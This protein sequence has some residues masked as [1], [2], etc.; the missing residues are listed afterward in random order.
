MVGRPAFS[1]LT[2]VMRSILLFM[3]AGAV[4]LVLPALPASAQ[5]VLDEVVAAN[6]DGLRD[7]DG[8]SS[9][10]IELRNLT[11][12]PLDLTGWGLSDEPAEPFRWRL[13]RVVLPP[14]GRLVVFASGKDRRLFVNERRTLVGE[15]D[16]WRWLAPHGPPPSGWTDPGFDDSGWAEGPSGFGFGDGDDATK[17]V[18]PTFYLRRSFDLPGSLPA[19]AT[20]LYLHVDC[21][22]GF[23]AWLNGVEIA[24]ENLGAPGTPV[25]WSARADA[26]REA[27]LFRGLEVTGHLVPDFRT[28]LRPGRNVLAVEVHDHLRVPEDLS[29][30][31]FLTLGLAVPFPGGQ[32]A[33]G[34]AFPRH[35]LHTSFRLDAAGESLVLTEPAGL[36]VDRMDFGPLGV[37]WSQGHHLYG[38]SRLFWFREPTPGAANSLD[39]RP[40]F[41]ARV[42][43]SP[44]GGF[45]P[46]PV[47]VTLSCPDPAATIHY[48]LDG[49]EPTGRHPVYTAPLLLDRE[50]NVLRARAFRKGLWPG[51]ICT[52]TYVLAT[53]P[54]L[55][56][57][58]LVTDPAN[59]WDPETGIYVK[60]NDYFPLPPYFGANFWQ[61]WERPVHLEYLLPDG[62]L[63]LQQGAGMKIHGGWSRSL[64]QKSLRLIARGGYGAESLAWPFFANLPFPDY[65]R[66][67][68]RNAGN[69]WC[70]AHMRDA[71]VQRL[72]E[73]GGVDLMAWQP[74][75]VLLNGEYWGIHNL[76]ERQ[77]R[78]YLEQHH[79]VDPDA[80]DILEMRG[81]VVQG[82]AE[83]YQELLAFVRSHDLTD[84]AAYAQVETLMDTWE[85]AAYCVLQIFCANTDWPQNNIKYWRPRTPDGRWRWLLFDTDFG[86]GG[87]NG[88]E[89]PSL[90]R[91]LRG[92]NGL[93]LPA[94]ST[95]LFRALMAS[96]EFQRT[97]L[98]IYADWLN[99]RFLPAASLPVLEEAARA[100][101]P[102]I[103]AHMRRWG[104]DRQRWEDA[105]AVVRDFVRRR[106][107]VARDHILQEFHLAGTWRLRLAVQPPGAG[108]IALEALTVHGP[109]QGQYF[110]GV[111]VR[112]RAEANP[113]WEFK[114]WSDPGLPVQAQ[115]EVDPPGDLDLVVVFRPADDGIVIHEINYNPAPGFDPG[116]WVELHNATE[117]DM[118]LSG[119]VF[120]DDNDLHSFVLPP[121]TVLPPRGYL[122]LC[123]SLAAFQALF[124]AAGPALGDLGFAFSGSG[125]L[126]RLY[127]A[128]GVLVDQV[129]Y[130]DD[131]PWP[132]E[133]DGQGPTLELYQPWLDNTLAASWRASVAAHGTPGARNSVTP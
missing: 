91:M 58:S 39:G 23:V 17:V 8:D 80:V 81:Q 109:W 101:D 36:P 99:S 98:D 94:W 12:S 1:L 100:F 85:Y 104:F 128:A 61:D 117:R 65:R 63:V 82:S 125:E 92:A 129:P 9:D 74:V 25:A 72:V 13:P 64:P 42:T 16:R 115:V 32:G 51:P 47:T 54:T 53:P 120:R 93:L 89:H 68:L 108:R 41:V 18:A 71:L 34:L 38:G 45:H 96:P 14:R 33:D 52:A 19:E 28:L 59:L 26:E 24:R 131:P 95:E 133:P 56:V 30:I 106:P 73:G 97:F 6:V 121:G 49:S 114:R 46:G 62:R 102:E 110:L 78:W 5:V 107:A 4:F 84:P 113:G 69:D 88:V 35:V 130:D 103:E 87:E 48:S 22:D 29:A 112:L 55:P 40:G 76:R 66:L 20:A 67:V 31:P 105:M 116:D 15:G 57:F 86:L 123:E 10:W 3:A 60:G 79:G 2:T 124:P 127:D 27:R 75:L 83:H 132:P 118:D 122:V 50:V 21:D 119:W 77:D 111:P 11:A 7:E 126:L 44:A 90:A 70:V 37:D 43:A